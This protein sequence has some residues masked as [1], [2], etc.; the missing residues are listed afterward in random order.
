MEKQRR[1]TKTKQMVMSILENSNSAL[2]HDDIEKKLSGT[3]DRVTIYRILQSFCNDGKVHKI[4]GENGKTYY[5]LCRDCSTDNHN[6]NHLHFRCMKCDTITCIDQPVALPELPQGYS[7]SSV[8]YL[9]SGFCSKCQPVVRALC[10]VLML[11]FSH[12]VMFGQTQIKVADKNTNEPIASANIYFPDTKTGTYTD[13]SGNFSIST[14]SQS[15]FVQISSVGYKTYLGTLSLQNENQVI[16]LE[17]S[18]HELQEI[19]VSEHATRLQGENVVN[20]EKLTLNNNA[21]LHG[22]SLVEKLSSVAGISNWSTGAGIGKPVIRGLSGNRIA[23]FSQ[24]LRIENQQWGDEH[25]L[26]L[27]EN[28]YEQVEIIK[29]PV[30]LLYGSDALGGILYFVDERYAKENSVESVLSSEYNTNTKGLRSTGA[31][32]LSKN[33]FH[34][35]V[36]GGYTTHKDY[37]DGNK[38]F[39]ANSRFRTGDFKTVLGYTGN[40]FI[41]S[42]K[43]SFLNEKYGLTEAEESEEGEEEPYSNGRKPLSPFQDLTTHLLSSENTFFFDN[44]SKL[45]IDAGYIFNNRKEFEDDVAALDMN[46][47]TFS[48]NAKWYLPKTNERWA[49]TIGSQGMYQT[50]KNKGEE[51]LIPDASTSDAGIFAVTDFYYSEKAYWMTGLRIDG[52]HISGKEHGTENEDDYIPAFS[53]SYFAFNFSTGIFQPVT[54]RLSFRANFS[55]G[56]RAPNMFEL[57]SDGAHEGTNRYEIGN[58]QL[59]TENNYQIDASLTYKS[60]HLELF[61]NPYFNYIRNYIYLQ[62]TDN[63]IDDMPVYNYNQT[64]AY[65]Y[66]GEAGFHLHP[67]PL[68]WLHLDASYSSTFGRNKHTDLPLMPSQKINATASAN[69][70]WNEAVKRFSIYMQTIYS[71]EQK[72]IAE[73]E[74]PTDDYLLLNAGLAFEFGWNKQ[75]L[76]LN[77]SVN[78]LLNKTYYDHLSR[79][80][81]DGI[82]NMGRN[83]NVKLS[84]PLQW[85]L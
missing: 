5:A 51:I 53:K 9:I 23:V 41:T 34:W 16:L 64:N 20:V 45:K 21:E 37:T 75:R 65:L 29:G 58:T 11:C 70:A 49:F 3:I 50:N 85:K 74:L 26:G 24:G 61:V 62:P 59:K 81:A 33:R 78:N 8:F 60:K 84:I 42:L 25:G 48:Y 13:E 66:G 46:L 14:S 10:I 32:K 36:F 4:S 67:H 83:I 82:Y 52:R 38:D 57:L 76:L 17:P 72:R 39:V 69:F 19:V 2:C 18:V 35:N 30:S 79:Y 77:I 22:F 56:Y 47:N 28:G 54:E 31:F 68:D 44:N 63:E 73:Y 1:N 27:D 15:L 40:K 43:Y 80:K 71:F 6:D 7:I 12:A 55:S